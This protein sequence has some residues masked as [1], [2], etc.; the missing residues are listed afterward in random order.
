MKYLEWNNAIINHFFNPENEEQEVTLY[1]SEEVINEIG[2]ENFPLSEDGYVEDFFRALRSGVYGTQ[3]NDYIQRILDLENRYQKGLHIDNIPFNYPPYFS[4]LLAFMLPF[5]SGQLPEGFR[6]TNFHDIVKVYFEG[7]QLTTNY[8]RQIK[9]RLNEIDYLWNKLFDWLFETNNITLG[10]IEKIENPALNRKYVSKFEYHIIFRKE[11]EDKLSLIFDDNNV[12]PN[13]PIDEARIRQLLID[14]AKELRL[15][16]DIV[17]KIRNNEYIGDKLVKRAFNYYKNWNGTNRYDYSKSSGDTT[18][19]RGFSIKRVVLCLNFSMLTQKIEIKHFRIYSIDGLPEEFTLTDSVNK[20]YNN[21]EQCNQ[22]SLYSTPITDCFQTFNQ[23]IELK[24]NANRIKYSWKAKDF[25]LFKKDSQLNDWVEIP[26]I[27]FNVGKTLIIVTKYFFEEKLKTWF[28]DGTIP[29]N[30][31]KLYDDNSK[32]NLPNEWLAFTVEHITQYQHPTLLE[33]KTGPEIIPKINFDKEFYSDACFYSDIL[34]NV[35]VENCEIKNGQIFAV[36]NGNLP[37]P[38]QRIDDSNSFLFTEEHLK[39][40]NQEFKLK[41]GNIEYPRFIKIVDFDKRKTNEEI[42]QMQ[43]KRNLIGD[44]IKSFENSTNYFQGIEHC[45]SQQKVNEL[46]P[47]QALLENNTHVF[48]NTRDANSYNQNDDYVKT[49]KGNILLNYISAKGKI[50][51]SEYDCAT[52]RLLQN[53]MEQENLKKFIR[54]SLYDLQNLGYVDYDSEQGI[55]CINKSSL[56]VKPTESGTTLMLTGARDNKFVN[57]IIEYAKTGSCYIDIQE[58]QR[59]LLPKTIFI[60]FKKCNHTIVN[61]FATHFKLQF[62]HEEELFTQFALANAHKLIDWQNFVNKTNDLNLASDYEGGEIFDI[63]TLLF[64]EK[65]DN[66]DKRLAFIRFQNINGY[67]TAYRLW[68]KNEAYHIAEQHYGVYLYLYLYRQLKT[69]QHKAEKER[70]EVNT[71]EYR[72]KELS[73]KQLTNILLFDE[74]KNWLGVPLNCALPK[75]YSIAF[76]LLSG[77]NPEIQ[78][79]NNRTYLIYKNVPFLFCNNS[80]VTTLQQQFDNNNKKQYIFQ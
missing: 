19:Q 57:Q 52:I 38:L 28:E 33:L 29:A 77:M 68:Y 60:I 70:G 12:L 79:F 7:K 64:K 69:E 9:F 6:M 2:E 4:Y 8:E 62:K 36:F 66:F 51:K 23:S 24:D 3:N 26:Q 20:K 44:T 47:Y 48:K 37:I 11:Q 16:A 35:W 50:S 54:Y 22:N 32:T 17:I 53:S 34:P 74:S 71:Y 42:K 13:E 49:H 73:I 45:F 75:Y 61:D 67:K 21:I 56:V 14:N 18:R 59:G 41:Y 30:N 78:W 46:K 72:F 15:T 40:K 25:Y 76:T 1:F 5:T 55:I 58:S 43:P 65:P 80:L 27:E 10:Y 63:E 31:K 39:H